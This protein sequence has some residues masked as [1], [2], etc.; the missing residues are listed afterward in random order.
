MSTR[1]GDVTD[2]DPVLGIVHGD[3]DGDVHGFTSRGT[4]NV[5]GWRKREVLF[6]TPVPVAATVNE[7]DPVNV[8]V[9]VHVP[10]PSAPDPTPTPRSRQA[11]SFAFAAAP[12]A[13]STACPASTP[14]LEAARVLED[15]RVSLAEE[16]RRGSG[17]QRYT[18]PRAIRHRRPRHVAP[19]CRVD[20]R[21]GVRVGPGQSARKVSGVVGRARPR[22][23]ENRRR[24][25]RCLRFA[26]R[27][28][29]GQLRRRDVP[30]RTLE[31]PAR[32]A[33]SP[34][35]CA[36]HRRRSRS[37]PKFPRIVPDRDRW[38]SRQRPPALG[39]RQGS[40][41]A[42]TTGVQPMT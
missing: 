22:I 27:Q 36:A 24:R 1:G 18:I 41:R 10:R 39:V 7:P 3:G 42:R 31:V 40:R 20:P 4:V 13:P 23:D 12:A 26:R 16:P 8:A 21:L 5:H 29:L 37:S 6:F 34:A 11:L 33:A 2:P 15:L 30:R 38:S 28:Q 17:A 14:L 32:V 35:P 9:A 19:R 25:P